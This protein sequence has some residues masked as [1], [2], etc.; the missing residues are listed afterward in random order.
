MR[1]TLILPDNLLNE[2]KKLTKATKNTEAI[3]K[4]LEEFVQKRKI[5]KLL[6]MSGKVEIEN[7][8]EKLENREL[9]EAS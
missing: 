7:N 8:I 9:E 3:R 4:A 1:T 6:N 5:E 2:T